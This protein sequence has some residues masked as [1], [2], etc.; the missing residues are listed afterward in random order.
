MFLTLLPLVNMVSAFRQ[1]RMMPT[2]Q[3]EREELVKV[4]IPY[5]REFETWNVSGRYV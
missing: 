4:T 1:F 2:R 5:D 3:V